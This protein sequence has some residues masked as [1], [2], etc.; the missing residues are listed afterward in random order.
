MT[1]FIHKRPD[2][3]LAVRG[4]KPM[5]QFG[6]YVS[7]EENSLMDPSGADTSALSVAPTSYTETAVGALRETLAAKALRGIDYMQIPSEEG[8][9]P[10]AALGDRM[11]QYSQD[12]LEFLG[13]SRSRAELA[14]RQAQVVQT[15]ESLQDMAANPVTAIATSM[16]D[17][18][19]V[20]GAGVGSAARL[21]RTTRLVAGLAANSAVL[22]L[23]NEGGQVTA[24]DVIGTS[25]G[26]ALGAVPRVRRAAEAV[27]ETEQAATRA[28]R[29]VDDAV[30]PEVAARTNPTDPTENVAPAQPQARLVPD[31]DY[32]PPTP[33]VS[34][35]KPFVEVFPTSRGGKQVLQTSARNLVEGVLANA[36]DLPEGT[37]LLGRALADSLAMDGDVPAVLRVQGKTTRDHVTLN[38]DGS[39]RAR[40]Y[41]KAGVQGNLTDTLAKATAYEK[42]IFLHEAVHAKT[43]L[44]ISRWEKGLLPN[45][46]AKAAIDRIDQIRQVVAGQ[47]D[48]LV[49]GLEEGERYNVDYALK[50]NHEFVAQLMN[51]EAYRNALKQVQ[52]PGEGRSVWSALVEKIMQAFT[53]KAPT[54]SAFTQLV[55]SFEEL[56][57]QPAD[58]T[59]V[60]YN[61]APAPVPSMQFGPLQGAKSVQELGTR[62]GAVINRNFALYDAIKAIGS[63]GQELA[64]RLVVD[65]TG[66]SSNSAAHYARTAHLA[67]N[68][69]TVQVDAAMSQALTARGW[70]MFSRLRNPRGFRA[71]QQELSD[72]VYAQLAENHQRHL[73]GAA[74]DKHPDAQ[75]E[76]IVQSFAKSRWAEDQLA[77]IKASKLPG[78]DLVDSSPYYLPRQHSGNKVAEFLRA[79]PDVTRA[80][81]E[82]MYASQFQRMF[83]DRGIDESTA[84]KLGRQMLKNMDER[85]AGVQGY[86]Q[87]IA[88][89]TDDDIEFAMR[90][91]GI[92]EDQ[93]RSFLESA[94]AAG[95]DSNTVRPLRRRAEFDMT[96]DYVTKS[97]RLINPQMFVRKDVMG[98]MENYSR[99]MSGR[100]GLAKAG[101][102]DVK[103]LAKAIDEA[104]AEAED[105]RAARALLDNTADKLL[106]YPTGE[107]VPDILRSFSVVSGSLQ[108]ANSGIYQLADAAL[109]VKQFGVTKVLRGLGRTQ[110]GRDGLKLA[111][112]AEYGSRLRDVIEAR[113]VLSGKYRSVLTH[114]EDNTDIGT[115]GIAHQM[116]QQYGQVTRFANGMEFVRRGQV[117]LVAGL[118]ADTFDDAIRGNADALGALKRFGM[119]DDLITKARAAQA[120]SAD[121]RLWP[122]SIRMEMENIGHSMADS[123]VLENRLGELPAWMQFSALGKFIMPYMNFVAGTWNKILRRSYRQ[124][125]ATGVAMMFAYQLPL[126]AVASVATM[127]AGGKEITP[128]SLTSNILTQMPLMSWAGYAVNMLTQGPSNSIAALG[129]VDKAYSATASILSGDPDPAQIVRAVPF[130]SIVPGIRMMATAM[131]DDDE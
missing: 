129:L 46:A 26:V 70:N 39:L 1:D 90:N 37:R 29:A 111:Q 97:G 58:F 4:T 65:A 25:L 17:I 27:A 86:R 41:T 47:R 67:A 74:I 7:G 95:K 87:H 123:L 57:A 72:A 88:G 49:K 30:Q 79:T 55:Q 91:A 40:V 109:M 32:V 14:Q 63:R 22:G 84:G 60:K 31:E 112:S 8:F 99:T 13:D 2:E 115:L 78:S 76:A 3:D 107:D 28:E 59:K 61:N 89:M 121:L 75:V 36:D 106:G 108:L 98:L 83:A 101:F 9:N 100:I 23:A 92:E 54:D 18:D 51:S 105:P 48:T 5:T 114:L 102:P 11:G 42:S 124:E 85:A 130:L 35:T 127:A 120:G 38:T 117:K 44:N 16:L 45:N 53:G 15:R 116:V 19:A 43:M 96:A 119:T 64:D 93:I 12:E 110:W 24:L 81:I 128:A 52:L 118:V 69:A 71:A 82:G 125:G 66:T 104:A 80:D 131:G 50:N 73:R 103:S 20:I 77:S 62:A 68:T 6:S 21:A 56:L 33:D 122:D 10:A 94:K 113:H 34:T 126:T